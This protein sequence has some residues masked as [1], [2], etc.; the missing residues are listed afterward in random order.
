MLTSSKQLGNHVINDTI[1]LYLYFLQT[2]SANKTLYRKAPTFSTPQNFTQNMLHHLLVLLI[3]SPA[4]D[5]TG[6]M[7]DLVNI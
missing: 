4:F 7:N 2:N 6:E 3:K 5:A 1:R